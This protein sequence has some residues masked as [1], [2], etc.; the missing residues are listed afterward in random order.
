MVYTCDNCNR[1]FTTLRGLNIHRSACC[2]NIVIKRPI[3]TPSQ[4]TKDLT[5]SIATSLIVNENDITITHRESVSTNESISNIVNNKQNTKP[6]LPEIEILAN[7]P[8]Q[9][10]IIWS[11]K[12]FSELEKYVNT[13]Y[14]E[15]VKFRKNLFK[16]PS[17]KAGKMFIEELRFWLHQ[18]NVGTKFNSIAMKIFM[19]LPSLLLQKP[20]P[21]SKAKDHVTCLSRRLELWKAGDFTELM[22]EIRYIQ[23]KLVSSKRKRSITDVSRIFAKLV[24]EGKIG[25]ALKFL[26][27]EFSSGTVDC[28]SEVL[29]N[30]KLLHPDAAEISEACLLQGPL[31]KIPACCFDSIDETNI[32]NSALRTKGSGGPSGMDAEL[33]RHIL[34]SK[35]F[36][37]HSKSLREEI[38]AFTKNIATLNYHP[39]MLAC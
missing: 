23:E 15:I 26:D 19:I 28:T 12:T 7:T 17:G 32:F 21:R 37:N 3:I 1:G 18:F 25:A 38:A 9:N 27:N 10:E 31:Q 5:Q 22:F 20:S 33:Y 29:Q 34:C 14:D 4:T 39:D 36:G 16:L 2:R 30:L 6:N 35:S 8:N 11:N 24:M 13:T